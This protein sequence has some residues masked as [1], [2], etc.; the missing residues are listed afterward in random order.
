MKSITNAVK[1]IVDIGRKEHK[2][3]VFLIGNTIK[4]ESGEFY[5]TP[6]RNYGQI[7][8]SGVIVYSEKVAKKIAIEVDGLIDYI[9]VDAEKKISDK[10]SISGEPGNIERAVKEVVKK[11]SLISYKSNDLTV[12]AADAFISEYYSKDISGIV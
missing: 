5:L 6:T 11:S 1:E 7:V 3:T 10:N 12:D 4:V 2:K 9:F 8:L